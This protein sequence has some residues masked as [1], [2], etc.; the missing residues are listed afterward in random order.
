MISRFHIPALSGDF[1]L[2]AS[3]TDP[4][5][6]CV[7]VT[8]NLT[9][10]EVE[11]IGKFL[12]ACRTPKRKWVSDLVGVTPTGRSEIGIDAPI[13]KAGALL[14]GTSAPD[15]GRLTAV[16]SV[17]GNM[18]AVVDSSDP[19]E[20]EKVAE[21]TSKPEAAVA[22]T[23][24]RPTRCCP[25]PVEGPLVRSSRVLQSFCTAA[26]WNDWV[27][28]GWVTARGHRSGHLYRIVHRH[29]PAARAQGKITW[30][31]TDDAVIHCYNWGLPPAEE[32]L[33]IKL[34]VEHREEQI[35]NESTCLLGGHQFR[36]RDPIGHGGAD[37]TWDAGQFRD[38]GNQ[39]A[40]FLAYGLRPLAY[41]PAGRPEED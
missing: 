15:K 8:E 18:V 33:S 11:Q 38:L 17:N 22:T 13:G 40:T 10:G 36:F 26:Q 31:L 6:A 16:R 29:H 25:Q 27:T 24:N 37:G 20:I 28:K 30:D 7:L 12:R 4:E 9:P 1:T 23:V 2:E 21:A 35:R 32:V 34:F 3:K 41:G 19:N 14:A 39:V 5:K